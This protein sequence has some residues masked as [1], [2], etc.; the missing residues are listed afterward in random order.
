MRL[1]PLREHLITRNTQFRKLFHKMSTLHY[2]IRRVS[3]NE[4]AREPLR[5]P[6]VPTTPSRPCEVVPT[7]RT[8]AYTENII[9]KKSPIKMITLC[10]VIRCIS[11]NEC[12]GEPLRC[13][14]VPTTPSIPCEVVSTSR[15]LACGSTVL[16]E[17]SIEYFEVRGIRSIRPKLTHYDR[18]PHGI[19]TG[20]YQILNVGRVGFF[21]CCG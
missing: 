3:P 6:T 11:T 20:S 21:Q 16:F 17:A 7:S 15:T 19:V 13:P 9:S 14:T 5:C 10:Y 2:V 18:P 4:C 12:E 8:L 1:R